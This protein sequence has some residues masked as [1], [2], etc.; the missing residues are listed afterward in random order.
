[1][2]FD[3]PFWL[4]SFCIQV[5]LCL[6]KW[7]NFIPFYGRVVFH[8][9]CDCAY[10]PHLIYPFI[11]WWTFRLL[12]C[13][14]IVNSAEMNIGVHVY[15]WV[16]I[17]SGMCP[18]MGLLDHMVALFLDFWGIPILFSIMHVSI[19]IASILVNETVHSMAPRAPHVISHNSPLT[20][21]SLNNSLDLIYIPSMTTISKLVEVKSMKCCYGLLRSHTCIFLE[22]LR[23][24]SLQDFVG[25][26]G[27]EAVFAPQVTLKINQG[28]PY[29]ALSN[30]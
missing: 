1:M 15:F 10:V 21:K 6:C 30:L 25:G 16:M 20:I 26:A 8:C 2:I 19:Y 24:L 18:G 27:V 22:I 14:G 3:F 13:P 23:L 11:C 29:P 4:T 28:S 5:H 7:H 17:F 12:P 9:V